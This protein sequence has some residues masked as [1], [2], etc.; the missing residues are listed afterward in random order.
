[1]RSSL[2]CCAR[3]A[4]AI[5]NR[6][7]K[8]RSPQ[9][10]ASS[11]TCLSRSCRTRVIRRATILTH[12]GSLARGLRRWV[13]PR[14]GSCSRHAGLDSHGEIPGEGMTMVEDASRP[15]RIHHRGG[16]RHRPSDRRALCRRRRQRRDCRHRREGRRR[17]GQAIGDA[18]GNAVF[19]LLDVTDA[20]AANAAVDPTL[21]RFGR[22]DIHVNNAGV[23]NRAPFLEYSLDAWQTVIDVNL[24]GAFICGQASARAMAKAGRGRIVNISSISGQQ[25]GRDALPTARRRPASSASRRPWP[26]SSRRTA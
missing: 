1:M 8:C 24:T 23:V 2:T 17:D 13:G 19:Q 18:G 11:W 3:A 15:G 10:R 7:Q 20:A 22:L 25:G 9:R 4:D 16:E 5:P 6:Q 26:W 14:H 21:Q 12:H